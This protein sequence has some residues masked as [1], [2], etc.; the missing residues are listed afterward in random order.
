MAV[1]SSLKEDTKSCVKAV[2]VEQRLNTIVNTSSASS[3]TKQFNVKD[4]GAV[5]NGSHNDTTAI[6]AAI[7][8]T[9]T[10]PLGSSAKQMFLVAA[11]E[12]IEPT[13][14]AA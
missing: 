1:N 12:I 10:V 7:D 14:G 5:G 4:Y 6:Q 8:L 2:S 3:G 13:G 9:H 11:V